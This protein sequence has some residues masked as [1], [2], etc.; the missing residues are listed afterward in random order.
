MKNCVIFIF[1]FGLSISFISMAQN[2]TNNVESILYIS[3]MGTII[4]QELSLS[5]MRIKQMVH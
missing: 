5:L 4:G 3:T 1:V 2:S